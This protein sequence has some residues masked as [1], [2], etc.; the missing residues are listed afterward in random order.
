[1]QH[2]CVYNSCVTCTG[3]TQGMYD[4]GKHNTPWMIDHVGHDL[5]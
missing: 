3:I 5:I 1:M 2:M 4:S